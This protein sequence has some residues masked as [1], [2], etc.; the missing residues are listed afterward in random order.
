MN[1]MNFFKYSLSFLAICILFFSFTPLTQAHILGQPPFFKIN[2]KYS[3][4]Y[5]VLSMFPDIELPQDIAPENY[6]INKPIRFELDIE[7]L[8]KVIPPEVIRRT[9]FSW[10]FG[11]GETAE[12]IEQTHTYKKM[13]TYILSIDAGYLENGQEVGPTLMQSVLIQI[14][15]NNN[16]QLPKAIIKVNGKAEERDPSKNVFELN[17]KDEIGF[18][19]SESKAP[20]SKITSYLWSFADGKISK[21]VV[22][23][24][25]FLESPTFINPAL[26]VTDENGFFNDAYVGI[27]NNPKM[28]N[29]MYAQSQSGGDKKQYVLYTIIFLVVLVLVGFLTWLLSS[30][31]KKKN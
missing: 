17:L 26:R 10:K 22:A 15:P 5:P 28:V 8:S 14:L 2:D 31:K 3:D 16:Y 20:S 13:G 7:K 29:V 19:A 11:D 18:D 9:T 27:K 6:L 25:I 30:S 1:R 23:K 24:H 12:G 21:S 4:L